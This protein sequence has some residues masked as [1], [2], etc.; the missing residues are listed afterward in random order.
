MDRRIK[1]STESAKGALCPLRLFASS[2]C[3]GKANAQMRQVVGTEPTSRTIK[4]KERLKMQETLTH[5]ATKLAESP[6]STGTSGTLG[7]LSRPSAFEQELHARYTWPMPAPQPVKADGTVADAVPMPQ[8][9]IHTMTGAGKASGVALDP[10]KSGPKAATAHAPSPDGDDFVWDKD[11]PVGEQSLKLSKR[12]ADAGDVYSVPERGVI[13]LRPGKLAKHITTAVEF[14]AC[15]RERFDVAVLKRGQFEGRAIPP[16]DLRVLMASDALRSPLRTVDHVTSVATYNSAWQ[17]TK[18]GYNGGDV[19]DR[20][21]YTGEAVK[22]VR[23]P[24]LIRHFLDAMCFKTE[25]DRTNVVA[26][27]LTMILRFKWPGGKPFCAVTAN[28]SH[29][30]K[31]TVL[32]FARGRTKQAEISWHRADWATQFEAVA[33]LCDTNIGMVTLGNI[34]SGTSI[35]SSYI[36]RMVTSGS[37]LLQAAKLGGHGVPRDA[38]FVFTASANDGR[39]AV[40]LVNRMLPIR[41]VCHEDVARRK[42]AIDDPKGEFLPQNA[43][44]IEAEMFGL[45]ENWRDAGRPQAKGICHPM[46]AWARDVGGI[47]MANGFEDFL[48]NMDDA[49]NENDTEREAVAIIAHNSAHDIPLRVSAIRE[50]AKTQ[51]VIGRLM[52]QTHT[53]SDAS[54]DLRLGRILSNYRDEALVYEEEGD[55]WTYWIIRDRCR[56]KGEPKTYYTFT[57][58]KPALVVQDQATAPAAAEATAAEPEQVPEVP[59]A[60]GAE[61]P[62]AEPEVPETPAEAAELEPEVPAEPAAA[63]AEAPAAEPEVPETPAEA[64]E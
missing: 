56:Q 60:A 54:I 42:S 27:A 21:Y 7:A 52:D 2:A 59:A 24:V 57:T 3:G 48:G 51:G 35:A 13:L 36:E 15:I 62:A 44:A 55:T 16:L 46:K 4:Y 45:I 40:D 41:L 5:A 14:E 28:K 18:P 30:G 31:D 58:V 53:E 47:L 17:L 1:S 64:A 11:A 9:V 23:D 38:D 22:P 20:F 43:A 39:F 29:A 10:Q 33:A 26:L 19:G 50:T 63:G 37:T 61:A 6:V 25:A 8:F 49:R 32:D 12:L 34:R